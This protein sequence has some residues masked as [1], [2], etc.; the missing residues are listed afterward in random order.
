[1]APVGNT[2]PPADIER[3]AIEELLRSIKSMA[4]SQKQLVEIAE[5][6][7]AEARKGQ[8]SEDGAG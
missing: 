1:V 6:I 8:H 2:K 5:S 7:V 3:Y 4:E